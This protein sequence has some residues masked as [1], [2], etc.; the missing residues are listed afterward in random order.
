MGE[1]TIYVKFVVSEGKIV[2]AE[3]VDEDKEGHYAALAGQQALMSGAY[4]DAIAFL[5]RALVIVD[6]E[7]SAEMQKQQANLTRQLEKPM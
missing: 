7:A 6:Y 5:D 2:S 3:R 1:Y 4:E